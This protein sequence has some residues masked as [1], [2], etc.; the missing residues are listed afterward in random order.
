MKTSV[1]LIDE[2][3]TKRLV[4][5]AIL[6]ALS[7]VGAFI[8]IPGTSIAFDS[9]P[10]FFAALFLGP[11]IGAIVAALGH[12]ITAALRGFYLTLPLHIIIS[13]LMAV[14]AY[15]FAW[16][17]RKT[18]GV[19]ASTAAVIINGPVSLILLVLSSFLIGLENGGWLL[20][21]SLVIPL[22]L[23]SAINVILA[24]LVFKAVKK[25]INSKIKRL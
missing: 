1:N 15:V 10:G 2:N 13:F 7:V 19:I 23:V 24:Y 9:M 6:I 17:Y 3:Y 25:A 8:N 11:G 12:I 16:L 20:F 4:Y 5:T 18:N 22:T 21:T 14:C